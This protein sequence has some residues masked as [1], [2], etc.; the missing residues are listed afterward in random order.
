MWRRNGSQNRI[1]VCQGVRV[2]SGICR[3]KPQVTWLAT[4]L[5]PPCSVVCC[6]VSKEEKVPSTSCAWLK[7]HGHSGN[8]HSPCPQGT[9]SPADQLP[10]TCSGCPGAMTNSPG[11][12]F[13]SV[14]S[15]HEDLS[16][17]KEGCHSSSESG[18]PA[19]RLGSAWNTKCVW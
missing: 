1:K 19:R 9:Y 17:T 5:F 6:L 4:V 13:S 7:A 2:G 12:N 15:C 16:R 14:P 3:P 8:G 18:D 11:P 10:Y